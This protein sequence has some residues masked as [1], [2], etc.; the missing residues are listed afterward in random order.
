MGQDKDKAA[1]ELFERMRAD[2]EDHHAGIGIE[3]A[4]MRVRL[5][6]DVDLTLATDDCPECGGTGVKRTEQA[7][8][9]AVPVVCGCVVRAGGVSEDRVAELRSGSPSNREAMRRAMAESRR[10]TRH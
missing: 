1:L 3:V 5:A 2:R 9:Q 8:S 4:P 6:S 10:R 7:G